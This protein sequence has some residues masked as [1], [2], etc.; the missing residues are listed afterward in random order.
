MKPLL[1]LLILSAVALAA[2]APLPRPP[3]AKPAPPV[4]A[5]V[6]K[7]KMHW[8]GGIYHATF[9]A[10]GGYNDGGCYAGVWCYD[11]RN[12]ILYVEELGMAGGVHRWSATLGGPRSGTLCDGSEW[13]LEELP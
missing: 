9:A 6:G 13:V 8:K 5:W 3:K 12:R 7:W 10:D 2:P 1:L 4:P 11:D